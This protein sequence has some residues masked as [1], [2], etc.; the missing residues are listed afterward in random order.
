MNV[1]NW[2]V[3]GLIF[4]GKQAGGNG[5]TSP[6][7]ALMATARDVDMT[8]IV[9]RQNHI[10]NWALSKDASLPSGAALAFQVNRNSF[11]LD[12]LITENIVE[13]VRGIGIHI[14]HTRNSMISQNDISKLLC[15]MQG[16]SLDSLSSSVAGIRERNTTTTRDDPNSDTMDNVFEDNVI[17]DFPDSWTCARESGWTA[18]EGWVFGYW[19]DVGAKSGIV[20]GNNIFN[21]GYVPGKIQYGARGISF[22]SRC[23]GYTAERNEISKI[24]GA[25]IE[26]R[27]ANDAKI[28]H[29]TI[30]DTR[31]LGVNLKDG[32]RAVIMNNIFSTIQASGVHIA[33]KAR[34]DGG[35]IIDHN[36]YDLVGRP[37]TIAGLIIPKTFAG[38][39][40]ACHCESHGRMGDLLTNPE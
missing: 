23:H 35:H 13:N 20:R 8:G 28:L 24:G 14:R 29:N 6:Q 18:S 9:F 27:N 30:R 12:S 36:F 39:Q 26:V 10:R 7:S 34:Q 40:Q 17:H 3:E 2:R 16:P 1:S 5:T 33:T 22:E 19:C 21:I 15:K 32:A 38:W 4:D 31:W 11:V 37:G 25:G